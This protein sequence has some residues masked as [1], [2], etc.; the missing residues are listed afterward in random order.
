[1][2][3]KSLNIILRSFF[4]L[5]A[6]LLLCDL[7]TE[8]IGLPKPL[9]QAVCRHL[10]NYNLLLNAR[11]IHCGI[12]N[13]LVFEDFSLTMDTRA[14]AGFLV[15][16]NATLRPDLPKLLRGELV[17]DKIELDNAAI[18]FLNHD[19]TMLHVGNL[20]HLQI[21]SGADNSLYCTLEGQ[22]DDFSIG[23]LAIL[24][25]FKA[26]LDSHQTFATQ[27]QYDDNAQENSTAAL[28]R[29]TNRLADILDNLKSDP[30][31]SRL[32]M[33]LE[34]DA[35]RHGSLKVSGKVETDRLAYLNYSLQGFHGNFSYADGILDFTDINCV[36]GVQDAV[37]LDIRFDCHAETFSGKFTGHLTPLT[38]LR[39][40]MHQPAAQLPEN[41]HFNDAISVTGSIPKTNW[42][43]TE[44]FLSEIDLSI[45][46]FNYAGLNFYHGR[47]HL[48]LKPDLISAEQIE[49]SFDQ[50]DK[51]SCS[52]H[53][54][55]FPQDMTI[56]AS[57]NGM[58][59][60]SDL[61]RDLGL[62]LHS[63]NLDEFNNTS[64]QLQIDK[65]PLDLND[66][67][68]S[69]NFAEDSFKIG[70]SAMHGISCQIDLHDD[71]LSIS[72]LCLFWHDD[73]DKFLTLQADCSW[74]HLLHD[75]IIAM[76]F[77]LQGQDSQDDS[78]VSTP[79]LSSAATFKYNREQK[80]ISLQ[81]GEGQ[82]FI[83]RLDDFLT[84]QEVSFKHQQLSLFRF[85][86]HP[87]AFSFTLPELH[88]DQLAAWQLTGCLTAGNFAF[89]RINCQHI[90]SDFNLNRHQLSFTGIDALC[91]DQEEI[92]MDVSILLAPF[93]V[94]L[95]NARIY[96]DPLLIGNFIF[97][98]GGR[99]IYDS[100][101]KDCT[102][103]DGHL[104]L[105]TSDRLLFSSGYQGEDW[106]LKSNI[107]FAVSNAS[108]A[109]LQFDDFHTE[110][111]LNLPGS[112]TVGPIEFQKGKDFANASFDLNF[113][114]LSRCD[115]GFEDPCG[116]LSPIELIRAIVPQWEITL[117]DFDLPQNHSWTGDGY[118]EITAIPRYKI[119]LTVEAPEFIFR[120]WQIHDAAASLCLTENNLRW[121][122]QRGEFQNGNIKTTGVYD[123]NNRNGEVLAVLRD[124]PVANLASNFF[125]DTEIQNEVL[126][127]GYIDCDSH[128]T[129]FNHWAGQ[130]LH[131]EG[132]GHLEL[133][134][135]NLWK[136]PVFYG[137]G[138]LLSFPSLLFWKKKDNANSLGLISELHAD[139]DFQGDRVV[140]REMT[141]NGTIIS[142]KGNGEYSWN[143]N[144]IHF[145]ISGDALKDIN[146][147]NIMLKPL[148]WSFDAELTGNVPDM[149][150][151]LRSP[152]R[153]IFTN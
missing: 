19:A 136:I 24:E 4:W 25:N 150:W 53:L 41:L 22:L 94:T 142:L 124:I 112:M 17:P 119:N 104:A 48:S 74:S 14:G 3:R 82:I 46:T 50:T 132:T 137:L 143:D 40:A 55:F 38:L 96:G 23:G 44:N 115:F 8:Y 135:G 69:L 58:V 127:T 34:H 131:L 85:D 141:T 78:H 153:K 108:F 95:T 75:K 1:M 15:A 125:P 109:G 144:H 62:P 129:I 2:I 152:L 64:V 60:T 27:S 83:D 36:L 39:T 5:C 42:S 111:S 118:F 145:L 86:E 72:D 105:I 7:G 59:P 120:K 140:F 11:T 84:R 122:L 107:R 73:Q 121:D 128:F 33:R 45:P 110:I 52:G 123:F 6:I 31:S 103:A 49:F 28:T 151:K 13:G 35:R 65:S 139:F 30:H 87:L 126:Q 90:T 68:A 138:K 147:L 10:Q 102:W 16:R 37:Q 113:T 98:A 130:P 114:G 97:S 79:F 81:D 88:Y 116:I 18:S 99:R 92:Q 70:K 29:L 67:K 100:I 32:T 106:I 89:D 66:L 57:L 56:A 54:E 26:F 77:Y 63:L 71:N 117:K 51:F 9:E 146:I 149:K 91:N 133:K 76:R 61:C 101:W 80:T 20:E 134:E 148:T 93:S 12:F 43:K 47:C 21:R